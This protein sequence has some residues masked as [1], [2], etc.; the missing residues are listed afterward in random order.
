[1]A[2]RVAVPVLAAGCGRDHDRCG[3]SP[4]PLR[5][6]FRRLRLPAA[7][8]RSWTARGGGGGSRRD[9]SR[10]VA[11]SASADLGGPPGH[12]DR[13]CGCGIRPRGHPLH[14]R[15]VRGTPRRLMAGLPTDVEPLACATRP[16][17]GR[18]TRSVSPNALAGATW[19]NLA[20]GCRGPRLVRR[21][22]FGRNPC[23]GVPHPTLVLAGLDVALLSPI[24]AASRLVAT[25][26]GGRW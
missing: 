26:R 2:R 10:S 23:R 18:S 9:G 21:P 15:R 6:D 16:G 20:V 13:S 17:R 1:M 12:G 22:F 8:L 5:E 7:C 4:G 14:A 3:P 19:G 11:Y 24:I 25:S